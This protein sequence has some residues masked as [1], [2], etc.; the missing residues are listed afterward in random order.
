MPVHACFC[1]L[2]PAGQSTSLPLIRTL[3]INGFPLFRPQKLSKRLNAQG[4]LSEVSR[5][6]VA[7]LLAAALPEARPSLPRDNAA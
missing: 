3:S 7:E 1:F 2:N 5:R 6:E 4:A